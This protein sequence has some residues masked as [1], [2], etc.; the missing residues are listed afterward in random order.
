[1]NFFQLFFATENVNI[2]FMNSVEITCPFW[3]Q[4]VEK[5]DLHIMQLTLHFMAMINIRLLNR[6]YSSSFEIVLH[7]KFKIAP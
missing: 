4:Y 5:T 1:M 7:L 3:G 2:I 6:I